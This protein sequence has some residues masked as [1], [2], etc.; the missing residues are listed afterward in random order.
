MSLPKTGSVTTVAVGENGTR[1]IH[2]RT[3]SQAPETEPPMISAS[4]SATTPSVQPASGVRS[5]RS[6]AS[7]VM[8]CAPPAPGRSRPPP[9]GDRDPPRRSSAA[10]AASLNRSTSERSDPEPSPDGRRREAPGQ[11]E[12]PEEGDGGDQ[13]GT[14]SQPEGR[15]QPRPEDRVEADADEPQG[16]GP[17]VDPEAEQQE[18]RDDRQDDERE[19]EAPPGTTRPA[20]ATVVRPAR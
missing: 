4:S 5:G 19:T 7:K 16:I 6:A 14:Q 18:D 10:C 13:E 9:N 20:P 12:V 3:V 15:D 8:A 11:P 1:W 2:S 17:Q